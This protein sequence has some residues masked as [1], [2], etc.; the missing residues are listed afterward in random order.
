METQRG[1]YSF[2]PYCG[3]DLNPLTA[4]NDAW[5]IPYRCSYIECHKTYIEVLDMRNIYPLLE[6]FPNIPE[7]LLEAHEGLQKLALSRIRLYDYKTVSIID[8]EKT[9][10]GIME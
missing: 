8:F 10:L 2:C 6:T 5:L 3:H 7:T 1:T 9:L 4:P